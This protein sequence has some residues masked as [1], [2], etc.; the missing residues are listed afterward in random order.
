MVTVSLKKIL[1]IQEMKKSVEVGH[2]DHT[3]WFPGSW[4]LV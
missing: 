2:G 3:D 1:E 4:T